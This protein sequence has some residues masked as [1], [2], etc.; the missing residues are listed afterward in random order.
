MIREIVINGRSVSYNLERKDVKN[1]NLRIKSDQ[2]IFVSA[3]KKV[4]VLEIESFINTK[5]DY[6]LKALDYYAEIEKYAP[7]PKLYIDGESFRLLGHDRRLKVVQ[8]KKNM[9]EC[10]EAYLT[11]TVK[12]VDNLEMKKKTMDKWQKL[13][14][15]EVLL[16]VCE[17]VYPKFQKYG[18]KFPEVKFRSM[19]SRWGSCQPKRGMLTFNTMLV[20]APLLCIEYV[21]V[22]EFTH[23]L[24]P[25]HSK[26]FYTQLSMF[27]PDWKERKNILDKHYLYTE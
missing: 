23:F 13:Y 7:K 27:L 24:Q 15:K 8:G 16:M 12:D 21:V 10:D 6:I 4:S 14:C 3:N 5:A 20:E 11:L 19:I 25:N 17:S 18:V 22:H 2:K 9:V 1:I 26:K